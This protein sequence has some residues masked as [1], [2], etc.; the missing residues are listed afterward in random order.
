MVLSFEKFLP[1]VLST[2]EGHIIQV[3]LY[4]SNFCFLEVKNKRK[5]STFSSEIG[6]SCLQEV[7]ALQE[8]VLYFIVNIIQVKTSKQYLFGKRDTTKEGE[9]IGK[10]ID[11][12][13]M[14]LFYYLLCSCGSVIR[15]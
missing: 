12:V 11:M 15:N 14:E 6:H 5:L 8:A 9:P 1:L 3:L 10:I 13:T 4:L 7:V 2:N